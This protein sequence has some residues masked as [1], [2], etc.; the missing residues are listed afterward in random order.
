[1]QANAQAT[2]AALLEDQAAIQAYANRYV[3]KFTTTST[4]TSGANSGIL[5]PDGTAADQI[6]SRNLGVLPRGWYS[7]ASSLTYQET[8]AVTAGSYRRS[9][10]LI[11]QGATTIPPTMF[12][13]ITAATNNGAADSATVN[14]WFYSDESIN[15]QV[16]VYFG[17]GNTGSSITVAVGAVLTVRF[18]TTGL[19]T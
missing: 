14:G 7:A 5:L 12:Q 8:G 2:N 18:L 13:S 10:I 15:T 16:R 3:F 9:L 17:H 6:I 4:S 19:V 11:N 1:M